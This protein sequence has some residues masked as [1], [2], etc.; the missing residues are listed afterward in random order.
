AAAPA[1]AVNPLAPAAPSPVDDATCADC[2]TALVK[3]KVVHAALE[4]VKCSAC[5]KPTQRVGRC[6]S[7][8]ASAWALTKPQGELCAGCHDEKKVSAPFKVKHAFNGRCVDCHDAHAADQ[9]KLMRASGKKLCLSCHDKRSGAREVTKRIELTKKFVHAALEKS[10]CQD[11]HDAGHGGAREA[12]LKKEQP[13]LCY[14]CHKRKD[15]TKVVHTAVRQGECLECH[16][17]HSSNLPALAKRPREQLCLS[18]HE[19]EPL[20]TRSVKHAPVAEGRCLECHEPHGSDKPNLVLGTSRA[21]CLKCHDSKADASGGVSEAMRVDLSRKVVHKAVKEGECTECHDAGHSGDN[22]R[23]LKKAPV[24]LCYGCHSRKDGQRYTHGAVRLGD[25]AVCHLPHSSDYP[26]LAAK[27][28]T[29]ETC[30]TCHQDDLTGRPVMHKPAAEGKCDACHGPHGAQNRW[31]LTKGDGK[32]ACYACHRPVDTGKVKHAALE[33][34]GCTGCHDPHGA[35]NRFLLGKKTNE[36]CVSCH[37]RQPDGQH[38][39]AVRSSRGGHVVSGLLDPRRPDR[40]FSCAS[41]HNPH[42]SDS[43]RMFYSGNGPM[44]SCDGCH[45]DRT[46]RNPMAKNVIHRAYPPKPAQTGSAGGAGGGG[47]DPGSAGA[48]VAPAAPLR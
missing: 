27:A 9:P 24:D 38:V 33:R 22:P 48:P 32:Q 35:G 20:L 29:R 15:T 43:P 30:F 19:T 34:Y 21:V 18:C 37:A 7:A 13:E 25:C 45:G 1:P 23:L 17:A 4:K 14:G 16:D 41:C 12:L 10:E 46:G 3:R 39:T 5:H 2:H 31:V 28:T 26:K 47:G 6:K 40:E 8:S 36:L 42:G 44:E 11:C